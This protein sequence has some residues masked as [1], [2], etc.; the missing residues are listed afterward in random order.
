MARVVRCPQTLQVK[1]T[2]IR[3]RGDFVKR[4]QGNVE[5]RSVPDS[6]SEPAG[7]DG[8]SMPDPVVHPLTF[9]ALRTNPIAASCSIQLSL[10]NQNTQNIIFLQTITDKKYHL[11]EGTTA[12]DRNKAARFATG[13]GA[14]IGLV[15]ITW[16]RSN[17]EELEMEFYQNP[18]IGNEKEI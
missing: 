8:P 3:R 17:R 5:I 1:A 14:E 16:K 13:I 18:E 10:K 7:T 11:R 12:E 6:D 4:D 9:A 15:A 2:R